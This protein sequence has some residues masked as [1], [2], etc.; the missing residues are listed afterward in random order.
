M[1]EV[2]ERGTK[3]I[4]ADIAARKYGLNERQTAAL[5]RVLEFGSLT[6]R[7]LD[8]QFP[9]VNRRTLQRDMRVLVELGL[10]FTEGA[11]AAK[12]GWI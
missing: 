11:I 8:V 2:K 12:S 9:D 10:V 3:V 6:V 4:K 5:S 7:D 1:D